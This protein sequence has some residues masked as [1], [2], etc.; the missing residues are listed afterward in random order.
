MRHGEQML[1]NKEMICLEP[2]YLDLFL[3]RAKMKLAIGR[4]K[5]KLGQEKHTTTEV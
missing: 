1:L 2:K 4:V 3:R 5:V